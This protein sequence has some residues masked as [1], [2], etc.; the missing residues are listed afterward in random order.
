MIRSTLIR[1]AGLAGLAAGILGLTG[2]ILPAQ[3]RT[4][5]TAS[6]IV[7]TGGSAVLAIPGPVLNSLAKAGIVVLPASPGTASYVGNRAKITLAVSGGDATFVGTTGTL[8]LSG[9]LRISDGWTRR[10]VMLT[11][12]TFSYNSA[13]IYGTDGTHRVAIGQVGG[14]LNGT[15]NG[16][17][18]ASQ[19]FTASAVLLTKSGARFL[20]AALNTSSLK[21]G[22]NLA[23]F[24]TTYDIGTAS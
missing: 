12:L 2:G 22:L 10:Y 9:S 21:A 16:G 8:D 18:P 20:N 19:T 13:S 4:A 6:G 5:S 7:D 15:Q 17:P 23:S 3:A 24:A 14:S 1:A 11:D